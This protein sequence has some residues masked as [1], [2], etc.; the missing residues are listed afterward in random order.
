MNIPERL[1]RLIAAQSGDNLRNDVEQSN[2]EAE[3]SQL[4]VTKDSELWM[5]YSQFCVVNFFSKSSFEALVDVC[6][7]GPEIKVGT[8]FVHE[9]WN[10][11]ANFIALTTCEGEGAYLYDIV[12]GSVSDFAIPERF[13]KLFDSFFEFLEWYLQE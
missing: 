8:A 7:P 12:T 6:V 3:L 4:G 13:E 10:V 1:L 2:A 5:V 9:V 11:P